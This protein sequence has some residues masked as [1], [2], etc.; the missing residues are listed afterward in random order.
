MMYTEFSQKQIKS[1]LWWKMPDTK[2]YDAI[3]CDGS[4]R[5]GKTMSMTI[6]FVMWSCYSFSGENFAFCGKTIDSLKRNVITP[7]QKW[8]EGVAKI[9]LN[10]SRNYCEITI[11]NNTNRY[12]FFGGKDESSYQ[13]IQGI[14][15]AGVL[16]DEVALMP[17]SFVDQALA[18]CSVDGSKIWFNCN[19]DS[20]EHWFYREWVDDK[21]EKS[22]EKNR[23]H[24][25]F[26]MN[27]NY[28]LSEAVKQ[29]YERMYTGVFYERYIQGLWVLAEGLIYSMWSDS[30]I[31][32]EFQKP[33][34]YEWYVSMDYGTV[35]PCSMGLWCVTEHEAIRVDEYYFNS[36]EEGYSRTDEEHYAELEKLIGEKEI[37]SIIIDP[38]AASFIECIRRHGKYTVKRARNEVL[39]GIR[40]TSTLIAAG[41]IRVCNDCKGFLKEVKLYRWDDKAKEDAVIKENDH[42]MDDTRYLVNTVLKNTILRAMD[43]GESND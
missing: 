23:L 15:L 4:V 2:D 33:G 3:V 13:L 7:M 37:Q 43:G 8:L 31:I 27:D 35:N 19:P 26:T 17:K 1:M 36:R 42:A 30:Y 32:N 16:L 14:T 21:S 12:Y 22:K 9:K 25:H 6:G 5:S 41:K 11:E 34:F 18:R 39:D 28:S 10:L 40:R 24:L 29:R 20:S 38:S